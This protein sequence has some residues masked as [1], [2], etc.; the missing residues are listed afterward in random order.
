MTFGQPFKAG[1]WKHNTQGLVARDNMNAVVPMQADEISSHRDGSARFAVI[2]AKLTGVQ[3]GEK[4]IINLFTGS[5]SATPQLLPSNPSW[6]LSLEA[7]IFNQQVTVVNFGDRNGHTPGTP[8]LV[9]EK[10]TMT[11][12]GPTT[13]SFQLTINS[14][15]AGGAFDTLTKIAEAFQQLVNS[16]SQTYLGEKIGGGYE[17]LW[18]RTKNPSQGAFQVSFSYGGQAK[19]TQLNQSNYQAPQTWTVNGQDLLKQQITLANAS[20]SSAVRRFHGPVASEFKLAIPFK[21]ASTGETHNFLTARLDTRMFEAGQTT[22]TNVVIENNWTYKAN[23]RNITYEMAFKVNGST[24]HQQ[25]IFTHYHHAR[26]QK[27]VWTGVEPKVQLRHNM[28]YFLDSRAVWNYDLSLRVPEATL[29]AEASSLAQA[30][31][32]QAAYGPMGNALLNPSFGSTGGRPEIGPLPKW[33]AQYLI[34]QDERARASMMAVADASAAIPIHFRDENTDS[35]INTITSP[36]VSTHMNS[37]NLPESADPSIWGPDTAHQAS[38]VYVPYLLTGDNFYLDEAMFWATWNV[39]SMPASYREFDKSLINRQQVRGSAWAL[40][41]IGEAYRMLPDNHNMKA[42]FRTVLD[43]NLAWYKQNYVTNRLGSPMGA[44]QH[45][46]GETP[47]WQNDFV[48]TVMAL[49]AE[50]TEPNA[51]EAH[52]WF[53]Q[54]NVG[55]F[56]NDANGFCAARAPGY[57]WFNADAQGTYYT[58][59]SQLYARNYASDV[60]KPCSSITDI[61]GYPHMA[62]GYAAY[63]RGMLGA[64][65]GAQASGAAAAYAK[66]KTMTPLMD[67][68]LAKEPNWAIVPR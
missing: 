65:A 22:R 15:T 7:K 40:R 41:S 56:M 36:N 54:F 43:N 12:A 32:E 34:S 66:W 10:I 25:P 49:L 13:E 39:F 59:W 1:D 18:L 63:A 30:R 29:A 11:I 14:T 62:G 50:N 68:E 67:A 38:Y 57:Y 4:R 46:V 20:Q 16:Q 33:T 52:D 24:V 45:A 35:P 42:Y 51:K 60:G 23:P 64:A 17:K 8:F 21:N 26:W 37:I 6:N 58:T 47:P 2:N 5:A 48:G 19:I 53:S 9:G 44:I 28:R 3:P 27:V 55:R 31:A 61:G